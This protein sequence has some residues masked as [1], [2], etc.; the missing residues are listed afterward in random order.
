M[1]FRCILLQPLANLYASI[2]WRS[3][4]SASLSSS[5]SNFSSSSPLALLSSCWYSLASSI[6]APASAKAPEGDANGMGPLSKPPSLFSTAILHVSLP[7]P[8]H[9][10]QPRGSRSLHL[11]SFVPFDCVFQISDLYLVD[12]G[13]GQR[14]FICDARAWL[15]R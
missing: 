5:S 2:L 9:L 4:T 8:H 13:H 15:E 6:A 12:S 10:F 11:R 3:F 7:L 1:T 14:S